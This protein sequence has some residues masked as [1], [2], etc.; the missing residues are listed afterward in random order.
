[1]SGGIVRA[2]AS[3]V[4]LRG[5]AVLLVKR[6][7]GAAQGLWSLPGGHVDKGETA[8]Q[9]AIREVREETGLAVRI[10]GFLG[11]HEVPVAASPGTPGVRYLIS[12]HFGLAEGSQPPAAG[13]DALEARFVA[14]VDLPRY[15]L[16][17]GAAD[18]ITRAA[19]LV[20]HCT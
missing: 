14:L 9:A 8:M 11:E 6:G 16:T 12:V 4:V 19:R 20:R 3:T 10:L 2:G 13:T 18:L 15:A 17:D 5:G 1:M 7:K